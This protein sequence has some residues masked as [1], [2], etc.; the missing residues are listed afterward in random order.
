MNPKQDAGGVL[1]DVLPPFRFKM[2][3]PGKISTHIKTQCAHFKSER[4]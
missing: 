3:T 2:S 1:E 4:V